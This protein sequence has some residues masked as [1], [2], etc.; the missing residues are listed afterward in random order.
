MICDLYYYDDMN[1]GRMVMD[2]GRGR[3]WGVWLEW[4]GD[5]G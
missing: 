1:G 4:V 2:G 5:C 3:D